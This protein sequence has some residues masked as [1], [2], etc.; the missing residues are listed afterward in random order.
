MLKGVFQ[1][2]GTNTV[3]TTE[4]IPAFEESSAIFLNQLS[5]LRGSMETQEISV[6]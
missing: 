2:R 6:L 5:H 1:S 3:S 4:I